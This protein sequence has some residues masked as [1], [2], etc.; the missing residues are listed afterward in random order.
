M[1]L[2]PFLMQD[3]ILHAGY[4]VLDRGLPDSSG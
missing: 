1:I 3:I 2:L 4:R